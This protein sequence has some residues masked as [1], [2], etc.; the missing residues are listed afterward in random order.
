MGAPGR[1]VTLA[2]MLWAAT[3]AAQ[4]PAPAAPRE[5]ADLVAETRASVLPVGR[6]CALDSPR[7]SFRGTGFAVGDGTLVVTNLHVI[8]GAGDTAPPASFM[9]QVPQGAT[10]TLEGRAARVHATDP[11]HD[12]ALLKIDGPPIRPLPLAE[13][14]RAREGDPVALLGFPIGGLLGFSP[15]THHGILSSITRVALPA[16]DAQRLTERA[17]LRLREGAF[18]IYQLDAIAYPGNSGGPVLDART[19]QVVAVINMV[20]TRGTRE[21]ALSQPTGMSYAIPVRFVKELLSRRP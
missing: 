6:F 2:A 18:D 12:L 5:L 4:P 16:P 15:V 19:G 8:A 10:G 9:V 3:A 17:I 20:L 7:F 1:I 21:S 14:G 11:V 13:D